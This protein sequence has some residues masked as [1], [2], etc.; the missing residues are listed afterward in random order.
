MSEKLTEEEDSE[1][2]HAND[3][4][5]KTKMADDEELIERTQEKAAKSGK[6]QQK[7]AKPKAIDIKDEV[8]S[9]KSKP[10]QSKQTKVSLCKAY[11]FRFKN[12]VILVEYHSDGWIMIFCQI[13]NVLALIVV[14]TDK[15]GTDGP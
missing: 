12:Y 8:K 4:D 5:D 9:D 3:D 15:G 2:E 1:E 13:L 14:A 11:F 6:P 10:E 7:V